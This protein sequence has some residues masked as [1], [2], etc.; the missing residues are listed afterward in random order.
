MTITY[1]SRFLTWGELWFN[2]EPSPARVDCLRYMERPAP[3]SG[4][5]TH[6]FY[7]Y[8]VDLQPSPDQL[9]ANLKGDTARK[10][11]RARDQDKIVCEYRDPLDSAFMNQF[12]R[13]F[14]VFAAIKGITPLQ[15]PRL[16]GM[17]AAGV[18]DFAVAKDANGDVLVYHANYRDKERVSGL[19]SIS[20]F[21]KLDDSAARN[22]ISRANCLLTWTDF[23]HYKELGVKSYDFGGWHNQ[24][25]DPAMM[26]VNRFK[27]NFNGR[28]LHEYQCEKILTLK[29]WIFLRAAVLLK[30]AKLFPSHRRSNGVSSEPQPSPAF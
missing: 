3:V 29:G 2:N 21:R 23:L 25:T 6:D 4:A 11:R 24:G 30:R 10:I 19:Y 9:M 26:S 12:E 15:R 7:T 8:I 14:N 27:T 5:H 18:L 20:L 22:K 16:E 1:K 28:V 13:M 17:A